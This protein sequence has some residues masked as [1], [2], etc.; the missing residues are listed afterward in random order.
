M[1]TEKLVQITLTEAEFKLC[2]DALSDRAIQW[3]LNAG[4]PEYQDKLSGC[5]LLHDEH[6]RLRM[7]FDEHYRNIFILK[8]N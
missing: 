5:R 2:R 8:G 1:Q 7:K 3:T 6:D 4:K